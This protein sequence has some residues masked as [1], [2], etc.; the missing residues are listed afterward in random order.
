MLP[1]LNDGSTLKVVPVLPFH[2]AASFFQRVFRNQQLQRVNCS[3]LRLLRRV[4][5]SH[6]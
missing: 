6:A 1:Q 4:C 3:T 2:A 5:A